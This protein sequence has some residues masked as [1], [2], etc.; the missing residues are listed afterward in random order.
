MRTSKKTVQKVAGRIAR[1]KNVRY[2]NDAY[3]FGESRATICPVCD[4]TFMS[5]TKWQTRGLPPS[6]VYCSTGCSKADT[7]ELDHDRPDYL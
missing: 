7:T 4:R 6:I 3:L 2:H 5:R 1:H